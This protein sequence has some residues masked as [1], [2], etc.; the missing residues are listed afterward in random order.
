MSR[1]VSLSPEKR[2]QKERRKEA[3]RRLLSTPE[4]VVA[5]LI[6]LFWTVVLIP[7]TGLVLTL[8][9]WAGVFGVGEFFLYLSVK[10]GSHGF[11]TTTALYT[12][13]ISALAVSIHEWSMPLSLI[14]AGSSALFVTDLARL[15]FARRRDAVLP[16]SLV[17]S[18]LLTTGAVTVVSL[19]SFGLLLGLADESGDRS[20]LWV[21]AIAG[22][23]LVLTAGA[24]FVLSRSSA[25]SEAGRWKPGDTMLPP[26][27]TD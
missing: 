4:F 17:A 21:P 13:A 6:L 16:A 19:L 7:I 1:K 2:E 3:S 18:T 27:T 25:R 23:L 12:L 11:L 10:N 26:P 14:L 20:W 5:S 15:N 9:L 24:T 22:V 8:L